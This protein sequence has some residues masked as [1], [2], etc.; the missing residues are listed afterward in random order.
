MAQV[1][2]P[3]QHVNKSNKTKNIIDGRIIW[4]FV[5][6]EKVAQRKIAL[7]IGSTVD[8]ILD[9]LLEIDLVTSW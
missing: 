5:D 9:T 3:S 1:R 4:R 7:S 8:T 6:L 2:H